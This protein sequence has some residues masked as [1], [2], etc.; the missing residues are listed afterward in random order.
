[1][2]ADLGPPTRLAQT[3]IEIRGGLQCT[4]DTGQCFELRLVSCFAKFE[5][6]MLF[7]D[8]GRASEVSIQL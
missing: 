5:T 8:V 6:A 7:A 4:M 3:A 2:F 1:V